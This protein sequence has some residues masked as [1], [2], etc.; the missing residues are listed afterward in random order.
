MLA[1]P[2]ASAFVGV[3]WFYGMP[4]VR[5]RS[6]LADGRLVETQR[7]WDRMPSQPLA[8]APYAARCGCGPSRTARRP[9]A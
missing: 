6:L 4:S 7:A 5:L 8:L 9:G 1:A 3:D 2:D